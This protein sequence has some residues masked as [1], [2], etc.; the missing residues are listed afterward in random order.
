M[1]FTILGFSHPAA[2][3]LGL[4][5]NDLAILRWYIDFKESGYMNKKVID[6]KEFYLVIYEY[7]LL[8]LPILGMKKDAVYRRFKKMCDKKIFMLISASLLL[9]I[10]TD[11][12]IFVPLIYILVPRFE[13]G[14]IDLYLRTHALYLSPIDLYLYLSDLNLNLSV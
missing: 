6:G 3:N 5:I 12:S 11:I 2:Y 8:D 10:E 14:L 7:V 1:K 9:D 13:K 4:D